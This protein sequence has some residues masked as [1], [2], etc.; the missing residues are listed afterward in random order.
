MMMCC[1]TGCCVPP[2]A[3]FCCSDVVSDIKHTTVKMVPLV[4]WRQHQGKEHQVMMIISMWLI[5]ITNYLISVSHHSW[6]CC[7]SWWP[8]SLLWQHKIFRTCLRPQL[9]WEEE[10]PS[11]F[12]FP[13][14]RQEK[15]CILIVTGGRFASQ[16]VR[17]ILWLSVNCVVKVHNILIFLYNFLLLS[18]RLSG[19]GP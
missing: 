13:R 16:K 11:L 7:W 15:M 18:I 17:K 9:R 10:R 3:I 5:V 19:K 1:M 2:P 6:Q 12:R 8:A 4:S 14:M